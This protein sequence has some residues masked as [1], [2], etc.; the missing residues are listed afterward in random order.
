MGMGNTNYTR[1]LAGAR[2]IIRQ[3]FLND[4]DS[5]NLK[6]HSLST[7]FATRL[8][9]KLFIW[10]DTMT[11]VTTPGMDYANDWDLNI[12]QLTDLLNQEGDTNPHLF[13]CARDIFW[14]MSEVARFVK[15]FRALKYPDNDAIRTI[16]MLPLAMQIEKRLQQYRLGYHF[17]KLYTGNLNICEKVLSDCFSTVE[18]YRMSSLLYLYQIMPALSSPTMTDQLAWDILERVLAIPDNSPV[19]SYHGWPLIAVAEQSLGPHQRTKILQRLGSSGQKFYRGFCA[20][21]IIK[22]VQRV[23]LLNL[24]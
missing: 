13:G 10:H 18:I 3:R 4:H 1:Y 19:T 14:L 20:N 12:L 24:L 7:T 6:R 21:N 17:F 22:L 16:R 23:S 2:T 8:L 15:D 9:I 11:I 5:R